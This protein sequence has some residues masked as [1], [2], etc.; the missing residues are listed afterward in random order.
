MKILIQKAGVYN[1]VYHH[2][3]H[4]AAGAEFETSFDYG[5]SLIADGFAVAARPVVETSEPSLDEET[6]VADVPAETSEPPLG[7]ETPVV[8]VPAASDLKAPPALE[9]PDSA[10]DE[11]VDVLERAPGARR[12]TKR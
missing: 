2:A 12:K 8:N 10:I 5:Q 3:H 7:E 6:P 11:A 1:D 9:L 4:V